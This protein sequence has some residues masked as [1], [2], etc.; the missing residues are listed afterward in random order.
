MWLL[1]NVVGKDVS[2]KYHY[3][4]DER[5]IVNAL[6]EIDDSDNEYIEKYTRACRLVD[7]INQTPDKDDFETEQEY[8]E[9]CD[10]REKEFYNEIEY[11]YYKVHGIR[12]QED[13]YAVIAHR[14]TFYRDNK[15]FYTFKN[16]TTMMTQDMEMHLKFLMRC[17][18]KKF[19]IC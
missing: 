3:Q 4:T 14:G 7:L 12:P 1:L 2:K 5:D 8:E 6:V 9:E 18:Q 19:L 11:Y 13:I 10:K 16:Y 17:L 15:K